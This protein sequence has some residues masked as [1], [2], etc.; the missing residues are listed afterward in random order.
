MLKEA[1]NVNQ[2][3]GGSMWEVEVEPPSMQELLS[4]RSKKKNSSEGSLSREDS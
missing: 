3:R 1:I 4:H 2:I